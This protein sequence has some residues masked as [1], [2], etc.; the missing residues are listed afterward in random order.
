MSKEFVILFIGSSLC[1]VINSRIIRLNCLN[2]RKLTRIVIIMDLEWHN[3]LTRWE[4]AL[5]KPKRWTYRPKASTWW[6]I[7]VTS[8]IQVRP[9]WM[10]TRNKV[11]SIGK[12]QQSK[13]QRPGLQRQLRIPMVSKLSTI[14][15]AWEATKWRRNK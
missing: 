5:Q 13:S 3:S 1:K 7:M 6:A 10:Q 14:L 9:S 2:C 15:L 12:N 11:K 4:W 8:R